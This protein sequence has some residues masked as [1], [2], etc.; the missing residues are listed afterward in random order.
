MLAAEMFGINTASHATWHVHSRSRKSLLPQRS[1]CNNC[2]RSAADAA[3]RSSYIALSTPCEWPC[4]M[5]LVEGHPTSMVFSSCSSLWSY[6][7]TGGLKTAHGASNFARAPC[8]TFQHLKAEPFARQLTKFS[9]A[10]APSLAEACTHACTGVACPLR[11]HDAGHDPGQGDNSSVATSGS[12][13]LKADDLQL[14]RM[15]SAALA[16][17]CC[18]H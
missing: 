9:L 10:A 5:T 15:K 16:G 7:C 3:A 8:T 14:R 13:I 2:L 4:Q 6:Y 11:S 18:M 1:Q 17:G 12:A